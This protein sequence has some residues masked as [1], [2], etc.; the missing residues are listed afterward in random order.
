M[1]R[2]KAQ[3]RTADPVVTLTIL[4]TEVLAGD[5]VT[6]GLGGSTTTVT[7]RQIVRGAGGREV[8]IETTTL[9]TLTVDDGAELVVNRPGVPGGD[10]PAYSLEL[11]VQLAAVLANDDSSTGA[12]LRGLGVRV[13]AIEDHG[14]KVDEDRKSV[15]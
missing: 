8:R 7:D 5:Q 6:S 14:A 2:A 9:G 15:V 1:T 13:F 4:A 10:E 11:D 3:R 12:L